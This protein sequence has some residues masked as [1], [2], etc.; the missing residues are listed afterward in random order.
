M[1]RR[2]GN[3]ADFFESIYHL[4]LLHGQL[5]FILQVLIT[6]TATMSVIPAQ[7]FYSALR[8]FNNLYNLGPREFLFTLNYF[9]FQFIA[10]R[11]EGNEND[12]IIHPRHP[13]TAEGYGF[14]FH[15]NAVFNLHVY[16]HTGVNNTLIRPRSIQHAIFLYNR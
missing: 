13:L 11:G 5:H 9:H 16:P 10:R 15:I 4:F 7:G 1:N 14:D 8:R 3:P 2:R 6:A 12:K